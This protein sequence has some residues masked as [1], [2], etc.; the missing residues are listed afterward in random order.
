MA[1][2]SV[3]RWVGLL[4]IAYGIRKRLGGPSVKCFA[5]EEHIPLTAKRLEM[6]LKD[7]GKNRYIRICDRCLIDVLYA[8]EGLLQEEADEQSTTK[9][10][11]RK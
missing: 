1:Q 2:L 11:T 7:Q 6:S 10:R 5:C 9:T 4:R 3:E 8:V